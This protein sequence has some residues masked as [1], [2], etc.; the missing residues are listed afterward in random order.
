MAVHLTDANELNALVP[1]EPHPAKLDH[2]WQAKE[3]EKFLEKA[4]QFAKDSNFAG[5]SNKHKALYEETEK[6]LKYTIQQH[7][8]LEWFDEFFGP[9]SNVNFHIVLGM[10]NGPSSY[11]AFAVV[12]GR[13]YIYSIIGVW[14]LDYFG[15][16]VFDESIVETLIHE[17]CH[18]YTNPIV[19]KFTSKLESAGKKLH[20]EVKQQM[21]RMAYRKWKTMMYEYIVRVCVIQYYR[22]YQTPRDVKRLLRYELSKGFIDMR[23][24]DEVVSKYES[25]RDK[26]PTFESFFPRIVEFFNKLS[27]DLDTNKSQ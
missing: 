25:K 7:A 24:L 2:R 16:P 4:R 21:R 8:H 20:F 17:L 13:Q 9:Q 6:A 1:F 27:K 5:F 15:K 14:M 12:N 22:R 10:T 26:Y 3:A 18:S 19:D 11:G 23:E